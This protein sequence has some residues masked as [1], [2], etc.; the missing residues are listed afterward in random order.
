MLCHI[1]KSRVTAELVKF[2]SAAETEEILGILQQ[3]QRSLVFLK[4]FDSLV[5]SNFSDFIRFTTLR[6]IIATRILT[7]M[8]GKGERTCFA[9]I[10]DR[11]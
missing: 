1:L 10:I 7:K 8:E 3:F 4:I 11:T 5:Y 6:I 2:N 9:W